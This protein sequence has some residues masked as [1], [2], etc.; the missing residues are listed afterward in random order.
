MTWFS[1]PS[2]CERKSIKRFSTGFGRSLRKAIREPPV[3]R[4]N[5]SESYGKY[6]ADNINPFLGR[7]G[8]A[9][10]AEDAAAAAAIRSHRTADAYFHPLIAARE[11]RQ[12]SLRSS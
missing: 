7:V 3:N 8:W 2:P 5:R 10:A 11:R 4:Q 6:C 9:V 1:P 12:C